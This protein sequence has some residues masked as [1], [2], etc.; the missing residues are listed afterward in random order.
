M[1]LR[2][3]VSQPCSW[4]LSEYSKELQ[5]LAPN[6][7]VQILVVVEVWRFLWFFQKNFRK[8]ILIYFR[9]IW[10][11][12]P[13]SW[14]LSEYSQRVRILPP[15]MTPQ[16]FVFFEIWRFFWFFQNF[17]KVLINYFSK[18][19]IPNA[20]VRC[21]QGTL[22]NCKYCHMRLL[23]CFEFPRCDVFWLFKISQKNFSTKKFKKFETTS[24]M[25]IEPYCQRTP[26]RLKSCLL[27]WMLK[28]V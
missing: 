2:V 21:C 17:Q 28:S 24:L 15:N 22:K 13:C 1:F 7:T 26:R 23:K 6:M 20:I 12:Q 16:S 27:I 8:L 3:W 18:F 11:S 14:V 19:E 25:K 4:V 9:K 5:I 10:N